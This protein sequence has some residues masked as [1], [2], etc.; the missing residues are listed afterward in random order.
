MV[1]EV[2]LLLAAI[3]VVEAALPAKGNVPNHVAYL[4][5]RAR[6][7]S[8]TRV[9]TAP[10]AAA[11][12]AMA[13]IAMVVAAIAAATTAVIAATTAAIATTTASIVAVAAVATIASSIAS[14][15]RVTAIATP[16][17][18]AGEVGIGT[19][20][21]GVLGI[22]DLVAMLVRQQV[23]VDLVKRQIILDAK[24]G[25]EGVVVG[26][27]PGEDV[28]DH[29]LLLRGLDGRDESV[30][31]HLHVAEVIRSRDSFLLGRGELRS[32]LDDPRTRP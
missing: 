11:S 28:G 3:R 20:A 27:E 31:Q 7:A 26:A 25:D 19:A 23:R 2:V 14:A 18:A 13:S 1:G 9:A 15:S 29:L 22:L 5:D 16:L 6:S 4:A 10:L 17:V 12:I 21:D 30:H 32:D 24:R 8:A